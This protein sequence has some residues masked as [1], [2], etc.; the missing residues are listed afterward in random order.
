M[1]LLKM[2]KDIRCLKSKPMVSTHL[3][4]YLQILRNLYRYMSCTLNAWTVSNNFTLYLFSIRHSPPRPP[5]NNR[6]PTGGQRFVVIESPVVTDTG[7]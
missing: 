4:E 7:L 2:M 1:H 5:I 3:S 6:G